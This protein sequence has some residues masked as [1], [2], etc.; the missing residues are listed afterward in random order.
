MPADF[1][2]SIKPFTIQ[3]LAQFQSHFLTNF[4]FENCSTELMLTDQRAKKFYFFL[5]IL[6]VPH[7]VY[8]TIQVRFG[9]F[10]NN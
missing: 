9:E 4:Y 2:I 8:Q 3:M 7:T 1:V 6:T 5:Q 10:K